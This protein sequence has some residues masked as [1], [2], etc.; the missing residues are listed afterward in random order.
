MKKRFRRTKRAGAV[1]GAVLL[2]AMLV[3]CK[4]LD[5]SCECEEDP[6]GHQEYPSDA[7]LAST[8]YVS[9]TGSDTA[10]GSREYPFATLAYAYTVAAAGD[11]TPKTIYVLSDLDAGDSPMTLDGGGK[12]VPEITITSDGGLR[13]LTRTGIVNSAENAHPYWGSSVVE[14]SGG[15][16]VVFSNIKITG[17]ENRALYISGPYNMV[18]L[19]NTTLTGKAQRGGGVYLVNDGGHYSEG[20]T[21]SWIPDPPSKITMNGGTIYGESPSSS[22]YGGGVC[23]NGGS[24]EFEMMSGTIS[25]TAYEGGG[26]Y[27]TFHATFTMKGGTVNES[28]ASYAGGGVALNNFAYFTMSGNAEVSGN[29]AINNSGGVY[30]YHGYFT[31]SGDSTVCDNEAAY[32]GGMYLFGGELSMSGNSTIKNNTATTKGG[33]IY[34]SDG[35]LDMSGSSIIYGSDVANG[36]KNTAP[37]EMGAAISI[38][39]FSL[40]KRGNEENTVYAA[41]WSSWLAN[42]LEQPE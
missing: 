4:Q 5:K 37:T 18:T 41:D 7:S 21:G 2:A 17:G 15:A 39:N 22:G 9:G 25:G 10:I 11:K 19:N 42:H 31:M 24:A 14:V 33:G 28:S 8:L 32:G 27:V 12:T 34:T 38:G 29:E 35:R 23:I 26:V 36:L 16:K 30:A 6:D 40:Y 3:G 13:D 20:S 1:L